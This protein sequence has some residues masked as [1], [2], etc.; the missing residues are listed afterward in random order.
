MHILN[1]TVFYF[2]HNNQVCNTNLRLYSLN[3]ANTYAYL[4]FEYKLNKMSLLR[5]DS[6]RLIYAMTL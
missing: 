3:T 6:T 2:Y 4:V 1:R 5:S